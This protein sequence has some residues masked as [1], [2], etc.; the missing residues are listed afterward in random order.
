[1][2]IEKDIMAECQCYEQEKEHEHEQDSL[3]VAAKVIGCGIRIN[4]CRSWLHLQ[5]QPIHLVYYMCQ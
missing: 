5:T 4:Q 3:E 2:D 1:M